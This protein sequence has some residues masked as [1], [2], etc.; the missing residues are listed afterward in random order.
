[1]N[2]V[3]VARPKDKLTAIIK[4]SRISLDDTTVLS[5]RVVIKNEHGIVL[6]GFQSESNAPLFANEHAY[7]FLRN[8]EIEANV[9]VRY[10]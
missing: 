1:M 3:G 5:N 6:I 2:F 7:C 9:A 10:V 4:K 8:D